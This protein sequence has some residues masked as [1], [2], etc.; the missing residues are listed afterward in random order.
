M[1]VEGMIA[2]LQEWPKE[3]RVIVTLVQGDKVPRRFEID[4]LVCEPDHPEAEEPAIGE[5]VIVES[6]EF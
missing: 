3:A 2:E 6:G 4:E 5:I 1:T